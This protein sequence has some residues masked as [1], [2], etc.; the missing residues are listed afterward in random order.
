MCPKCS[1]LVLDNARVGLKKY[2]CNVYNTCGLKFPDKTFIYANPLACLDVK[3]AGYSLSLSVTSI[4]VGKS[5]IKVS[6][7]I[8]CYQFFQKLKI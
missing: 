5:K 3:L 6:N 7:P 8:P 4:S 2:V 1:K